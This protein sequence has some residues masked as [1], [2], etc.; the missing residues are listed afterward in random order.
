MNGFEGLALAVAMICSPLLV[1]AMMWL[2][3]WFQRRE[4]LKEPPS[5]L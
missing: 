2:A 1:S 5:P 4:P 3:L